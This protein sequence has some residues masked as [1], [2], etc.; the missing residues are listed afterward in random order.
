MTTT[1]YTYS[2]DDLI[3]RIQ[4]ESHYMCRNVLNKE[5]IA[6]LD[7]YGVTTN[8]DEYVKILMRTACT[9]IFDKWFSPLARTITE[10]SINTLGYVPFEFDNEDSGNI[11]MSIETDTTF[12]INLVPAIDVVIQDFIVNYVLWEWFLKSGFDSQY[13]Y[14]LQQAAKTRLD[15]SEG[16]LSNMLTRRFNLKRTYKFY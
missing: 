15:A 2:I 12:D 8:D 13:S 16:R 4:V 3:K 6:Q 11:V 10:E 14:A 7:E 9:M 1:V 5:G